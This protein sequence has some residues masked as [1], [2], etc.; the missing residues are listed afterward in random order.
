MAKRGSADVGFFL[1]DGQDVLGTLTQVA[2][3]HSA[4]IQDVSVLGS[5]WRAQAFTG[6]REA[7]ITQEGFYDDAAGSVHDALSS[8]PGVSRVLAYCLEG[9]ATGARFIGYKGAVEVKYDRQVALGSLHRAQAEYRANGP[10]DDGRTIRTYKAAGATGASTGTPVDNGVSS[11][12]AAAYLEYN[13]A[14]GEANIRVL[15]S[16][17]NITY[18]TLFTFTKTAAGHGAERL[19]TSGAVE[20]Y[21]AVDVTTASATGNIGALNYFVGVARGVTQ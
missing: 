17:D 13:A 9:T 8:G 2:D 21:L 10:V 12:G 19:Y 15:H 11:T 4:G 6:T 7:T 1:V 3:T 18:T 14:A 20:R 16:A 5:A